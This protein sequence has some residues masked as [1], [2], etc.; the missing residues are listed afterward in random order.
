MANK[1]NP[2]S[3]QDKINTMSE[4]GLPTFKS[5]D[6]EVD[7][8]DSFVT[9]QILEEGEEIEWEYKPETAIKI[10]EHIEIYF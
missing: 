4:I 6:E 7:F 3:K 2:A 10:N 1:I 8:W 5:A 9:A